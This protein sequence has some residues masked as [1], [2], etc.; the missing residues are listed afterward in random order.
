MIF[1]IDV[2]ALTPVLALVLAII[3]ALIVLV[4]VLLIMKSGRSFSTT[5]KRHDNEVKLSIGK[6]AKNEVHT[7]HS[8]KQTT[9]TKDDS[10]SGSPGKI[11]TNV[12][13]L[14]FDPSQI[15]EHRFFTSAVYR[16]TSE[17]CEFRLYESALEHGIK[18][19]P[20]DVA[21]FK[22][23]IATKYLHKCLFEYIVRVTREWSET[24]LAEVNVEHP[25]LC[26]GTP[27]SIF[28]I[29]EDFVKYRQEAR[30]RARE[31][32]FYFLGKPIHGI[33]NEFIDKLDN[34]SVRNM[35]MIR[36]IAE[37]V[38]Y[39]PNLPWPNK[40]REILDMLEM[41]LDY[42]QNDVDATLIL[43]NGEMERYVEN[44]KK[45]DSQKQV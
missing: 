13:P 33:P 15:T 8:N 5:F 39:T 18:N 10:P 25:E 4:L 45:D 35:N 12:E 27:P 16:Y 44:L 26:C 21:E 24:L 22:K 6:N 38:L 3:V 37:R 40:A 1:G 14:S 30:R 43:L 29:I 17:V 28:G 11:P 32:D 23:L 7:K 20:A 9:S 2:K 36:E 42:M 31:L 19:D 41:S 34:W